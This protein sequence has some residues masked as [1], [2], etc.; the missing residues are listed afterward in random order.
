MED[1][2]LLIALAAC[3]TVMLFIGWSLPTDYGNDE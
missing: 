3:T 1:L 2:P